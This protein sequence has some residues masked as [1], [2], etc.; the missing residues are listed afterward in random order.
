MA[1]I[2]LNIDGTDITTEAG[3][4]VLEAALEH[5]IYIPHLCYHP[6]LEPAGACRLCVV[7]LGN[8][9]KLATSCRVPVSPGLVV[10]TNTPAV[11]QARLAVVE[12]IIADH[13]YECRGCPGSGHC[14]FQKIMGRLHVSSKKMRPLRWATEEVTLDTSPA[15][16]DYDPGRCVLC[17]ICVRTS[18]QTPGGGTIAFTHRG[19]GTRLGFYGEILEGD[20]CPQCVERCP[21][22]ALVP[23]KKAGGEP[24]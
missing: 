2:T 19:H 15:A 13:H 20:S 24:A 6:E 3:K 21:V 11:E 8:S 5:D 12:L 22:Y 1:E 14:Q 4:S 10:R 18:Q 7:E 23:K 17:G 16:F 9:T